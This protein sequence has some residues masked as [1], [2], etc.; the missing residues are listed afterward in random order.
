MEPITNLRVELIV[1]EGGKSFEVVIH[2]DAL[3]K[4]VG[5]KAFDQSP[6]AAMDEAYKKLTA[7]V[8]EAK[9]QKNN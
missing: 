9:A 1:A 2:G 4:G 6:G 5:F 3:T 7:H 8:T